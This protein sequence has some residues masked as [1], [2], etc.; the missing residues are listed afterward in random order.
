MYDQ[1]F[2]FRDDPV[3]VDGK[4]Y[5]QDFD[6]LKA[7]C[8]D[9]GELFTDPEFPADNDSIYFSK[10]KKSAF[11]LTKNKIEIYFYILYST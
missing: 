9:S 1:Y 8:L 4:L 2:V 11:R 7:G 10:V 6:E 5:G 3:W